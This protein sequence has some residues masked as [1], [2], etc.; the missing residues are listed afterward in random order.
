MILW[1]NFLMKVIDHFKEKGYNHRVE[2]HMIT[3]A[4]KLVMT[5]DIYIKHNMHAVEWRLNA[6]IRKNKNLIN[7]FVRNWRHPLNR[8]IESYRV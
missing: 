5:F 3:T 4:N 1:K 6:M 2:M 8:K 7:K